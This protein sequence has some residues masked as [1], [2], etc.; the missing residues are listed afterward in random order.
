MKTDKLCGALEE[1]IEGA[2]HYM[3]SLWDSHE[4]DENDMGV[5]LIDDRITLMKIIIK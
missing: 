2:T 4:D 3:R 1:D 5:S